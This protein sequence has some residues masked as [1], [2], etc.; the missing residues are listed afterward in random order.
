MPT[1]DVELGYLAHAK[2][3]PHPGVVL[4]HDVW[5]LS[6]HTRH[7]ARRLAG[8]DFSVLAVDLYRRE[9]EVKIENPGA[10]MR[11]LSDP[12]VLEDL[13]AAVDFLSGHPS[14]LGRQ[15]AVAGFCMGG[16]YAI[17]AACSCTGLSACVACYGLLSYE[18]GLL[19]G[20]SGPDPRLKPRQPLDALGDLSCPL[21]A[22][23]GDKDEFVPMDDVELLK[24]RLE[25]A[26][27]P[28]Q[29]VVYPDCGH[30]FLN[31]TR[32]DAYRPKEAEEAWNL[33]VKSFRDNLA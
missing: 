21:V 6:D 14:V 10:W 17:L 33:M 16:S 32:A 22:V 19:Y 26:P 24:K 20:E 15:V 31:D 2:D 1:E 7:V 18:H 9:A 13:Q 4:I 11:G 30:A 27:H 29:V 5:G 28:G 8:E 25:E 23:Y 12:Q 3:G